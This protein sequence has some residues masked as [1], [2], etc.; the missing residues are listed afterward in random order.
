MDNWRTV[1]TPLPTSVYAPP[2]PRRRTGIVALVIGLALLAVLLV[3]HHIPDTLN[4]PTL[5]QQTRVLSDRYNH[6]YP[7]TPPR[8]GDDGRVEYRVAMVAD[9]DRAS[10]QTDTTWAAKLYTGTLTR[11]ADGSYALSLDH[12]AQTLTSTLAARGRGAELSELQVFDGKLLT[13][14]DRTGVLYQIANGQLHPRAILADGD[15]SNVKGLKA[16]W[17]T[18]KSRR[19]WV[20]GIGRDWTS[21]Q[22]TFVNANPKWVKAVS[23]SGGVAH[24][25]W[26]RAYNAL[27]RAAGVPVEGY[28][29][30]EA[31]AW[32]EALQHWVVA[33]RRVSTTHY[34][35]FQDER[36]GSNLVLLADDAF[37]HIRS[38][39][40]GEVKPTHG[41][42]S[43]KMVPGIHDREAVAL[44]T[45]EVEGKLNT[46]MVVFDAS[47]GKVLMDETLVLEGEKLEGIEFI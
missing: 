13:V 14:D 6:T 27:A 30:H 5:E 22:G 12:P 10:K 43:I 29:W 41:F 40:V 33:P 25:N 46:F 8:Q 7:F 20:G 32:S 26:T 42:S 38:L 9:P 44:K 24:I 11:R 16:E 19:L 4:R 34:D 36:R 45:E 39:A 18:V 28:L 21:P 47:S 2:P 35:E 37:E 15:G 3:S 1:R 31:I 23:P 17:M